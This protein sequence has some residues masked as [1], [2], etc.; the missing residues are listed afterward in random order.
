MLSFSS[1]R[2]GAL[3]FKMHSKS[4][5]FFQLQQLCKTGEKIRRVS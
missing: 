2:T 3:C 4:R 1:I 5:D